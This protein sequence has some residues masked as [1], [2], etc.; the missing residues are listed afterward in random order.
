MTLTPPKRP[1]D[2]EQRLVVLYALQRLA[3][4]TELQLLQ[5]FSEYDWMNYFDMMIALQGLCARGQAVRTRKRA[6]YLYQPTPAG[7]EALQLF[8][9]RVPMSVK[10]QLDDTADAWRA[11]FAQEDQYASDIRQTDRGEFELTL[12][13]RE[14]EMDTLRISFTLPARELARQLSER[15]PQKAGQIY[16]YVIRTLTEDDP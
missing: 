4:C 3:P 6:G 13:V 1:P 5:V 14:Q 11:R 10:K 16:E 2:D 8:G 9:G 15:W 12:S 7:E